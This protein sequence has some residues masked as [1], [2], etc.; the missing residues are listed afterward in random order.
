MYEN[1][2]DVNYKCCR[3]IYNYFLK[4]IVPLTDFNKRAK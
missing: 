4:E 1:F 3:N 2:K